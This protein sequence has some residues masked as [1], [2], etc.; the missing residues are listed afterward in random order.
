[1]DMNQFAEPKNMEGYTRLNSLV[2]DYNKF[3]DAW[4]YVVNDQNQMADNNVLATIANGTADMGVRLVSR[5]TG[6]I[7]NNLINGL[8]PLAPQI[9]IALS[10]LG[11]YELYKYLPLR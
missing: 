10:L 11:A 1:L 4:T 2:S 6:G 3:S 7:F 9:M 8:G 5:F